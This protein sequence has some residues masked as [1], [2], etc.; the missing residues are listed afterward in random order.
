VVPSI[1]AGGWHWNER[2]V[3]WCVWNQESRLTSC[4][5]TCLK[6]DSTPTNY[7]VYVVGLFS[8]AN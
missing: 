4:W 8:G 6:T 1:P 3:H 7:Y 5:W 2:A